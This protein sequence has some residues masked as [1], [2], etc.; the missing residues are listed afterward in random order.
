MSLA[1]FENYRF[2][3]ALRYAMGNASGR[4]IVDEEQGVPYIS[5]LFFRA[6]LEH[7]GET[8]S[9]QTTVFVDTASALQEGGLFIQFDPTFKCALC[10]QGLPPASLYFVRGPAKGTANVGQ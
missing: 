7:E 1:A 10:R 8:A 9:P 3:Q 4:V 2:K 5:V 6:L